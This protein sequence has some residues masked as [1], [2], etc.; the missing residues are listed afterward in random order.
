MGPQRDRWA[1]RMHIRRALEGYRRHGCY[2]Y[3][4]SA[5]QY[6]R[7]R[8]MR[9]FHPKEVQ[10]HVYL[11]H[12]LCK[13]DTEPCIDTVAPVTT[14]TPI[15]PRAA[16]LCAA[17]VR[18]PAHRTGALDTGLTH[19]CHSPVSVTPD[20]CSIRCADGRHRFSPL[21]TSDARPRIRINRPKSTTRR[22]D[23]Q[24]PTGDH[25][26]VP[27]PFMH[28]PSSQAELATASQAGN[29]ALY[30]DGPASLHT[31]VA[32]RKL[33]RSLECA[34]PA[35]HVMTTPA[36]PS[37]PVDDVMIGVRPHV[38]TAAQATGTR[39]RRAVL[40]RAA[41]RGCCARL[42]HIP[43]TNAVQVLLRLVHIPAWPRASS[44]T[45]CPALC[46]LASASASANTQCICWLCTRA[47]LRTVYACSSIAALPTGTC[48]IHLPD[49]AGSRASLRVASSVSCSMQLYSR[50]R[51]PCGYR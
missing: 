31:D 24:I 28:R 21:R 50:G 30:T 45:V 22:G 18:C 33:G 37:L 8:Q 40:L 43:A 7:K 34:M 2:R 1:T 41:P 15:N 51:C 49:S 48:C 35:V 23:S 3:S 27:H 17:G 6:T 14:H 25:P 5:L 9:L 36:P 19:P 12:D 16:T 20:T 46:C 32:P 26:P 39:D 47:A 4:A 44:R 29:F 10:A 11:L 38:A 42:T 13:A